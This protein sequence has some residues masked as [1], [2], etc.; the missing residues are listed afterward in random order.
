MAM[1]SRPP[2][3]E[4]EPPAAKTS[5]ESSEDYA[6]GF[7]SEAGRKLSI[8]RILVALDASSNSK[9]AMAVAAGLAR[10]LRS[11][12][13][14]LFIEDINLLRLAEL[15]FARE[16]IFAEAISRRI[17][18]E[19]LQRLFS[20]RAAILKRE[21]SELATDYK[22]T[23]TFRVLQGPVNRELLAAALEADLLAVGRLGHSI[24]GRAKL[25]ATAREIVLR[26]TSAVLLVKS[27][28]ESGPVI[29]LY[30]GSVAGLRALRL[31]AELAGRVGDM[32]IL[33][34]A[35]DEETAL[36]RRQLAMQLIR[37]FDL[38]PQYQHLSGDNPY[39]VIQ[40]VNRQKG[41]LLILGG[42]ENNLPADIIQ[43]LLDDAQQHILIAR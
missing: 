38:Q 37:E 31:A 8:R 22:I 28:V 27:G 18:A 14:G 23:S 17:E 41:S 21:L 25:G 15:P 20:A 12:L 29:A 6:A 33:A 16:V 24:I 1:T 40:W 19:A 5:V 10:T 34:W 30:D 7:D 42:G 2:V 35:L 11:E 26:A 9:E 36:E 4:P 43:I 32:R 39:Q 13:T 3:E